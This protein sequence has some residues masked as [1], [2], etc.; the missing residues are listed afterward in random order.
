MPR[1][2]ARSYK[3]VSTIYIIC[4]LK[5][6]PVRKT[7]LNYHET[8]LFQDHIAASA[9]ES[10]TL[11]KLQK[12]GDTGDWAVEKLNKPQYQGN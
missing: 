7:R 2:K 6:S 9:R 5:P 8:E 4:N 11:L 12:A 3:E 1:E 10:V